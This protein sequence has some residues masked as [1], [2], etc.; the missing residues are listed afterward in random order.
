MIGPY[1]NS[2]NAGWVIKDS[3]A[4]AVRKLKDTSGRY[5]WESSVVAGQPDLILAK[6]VYTDPY[7]P[8]A[9]ADAKSVLFGDLSAY[10]VR[11][12]NGVRFESSEHFAFDRDVVT[13]RALV[14]G[15][16]ALADQSGA[17]KHFLGGAAA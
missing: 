15:D 7:M 2:P 14:R 12:V 9:A 1:R 17:V 6:P 13:F 4:G 11:L 10:F 16:G 5:L 8:A 3:T